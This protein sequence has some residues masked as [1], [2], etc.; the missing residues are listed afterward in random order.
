MKTKRESISGAIRETQQTYSRNYFPY[1]NV[2]WKKFPDQIGH[3]YAPGCMRCHDGK[4][5]SEEG[6]VISNDCTICHTII[7]QETE[8]LEPKF[9]LAGVDYTHPIDIGE[10]W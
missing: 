2:S 3:M 10:T 9:S 8:G 4:H 1:M 7:G 5:F 6:K